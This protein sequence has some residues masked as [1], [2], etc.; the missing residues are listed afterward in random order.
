MGDLRTAGSRREAAENEVEAEAEEREELAEN[1]VPE[2]RR[3]V[4][5]EDRANTAEGE[6]DHV[7][8]GEREPAHGDLKAINRR[9]ERKLGDVPAKPGGGSPEQPFG[10]EAQRDEANEKQRHLD[11]SAV[12][13]FGKEC[14]P[15]ALELSLQLRRRRCKC[16]HVLP[17]ARPP[18]REAA[19]G[20]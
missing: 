1:D 8:G 6:D 4:E 5:G 9:D 10:P 16:R 20:R 11:E 19:G 3:P 13:Q 12:L 17:H 14:D 2:E 18:A 7:A 15:R